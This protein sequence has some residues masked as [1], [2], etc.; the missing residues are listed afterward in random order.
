MICIEKMMAAG[1]FEISKS[2]NKLP[3]GLFLFGF[4]IVMRTELT[5]LCL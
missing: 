2:Q 4:W 5:L 1:D 3:S